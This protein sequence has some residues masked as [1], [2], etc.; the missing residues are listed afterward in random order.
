[1]LAALDIASWR[2]DY[3]HMLPEAFLASLDMVAQEERLRARF[4]DAAQSTVVACA[5][6]RRL[7]FVTAGRL[8][9]EP[10]ALPPS[11]G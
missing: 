10:S 4:A 9:G 3:A 7:G 5:G 11:H 2:A 1:M 6:R 8:R